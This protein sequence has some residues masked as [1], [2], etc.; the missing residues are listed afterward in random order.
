MPIPFLHIAVSDDD[1]VV[2]L[3]LGKMVGVLDSELLDGSRI[4]EECKLDIRVR[5]LLGSK[6]DATR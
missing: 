3:C 2:L 1:C 5:M 4:L 6:Y